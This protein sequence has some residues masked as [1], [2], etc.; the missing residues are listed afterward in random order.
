M[1]AGVG[2]TAAAVAAMPDSSEVTFG[3]NPFYYDNWC[4]HMASSLTYLVCIYLFIYESHLT[5]HTSNADFKSLLR[6]IKSVRRNSH[7]VTI[8]IS[9]VQLPTMLILTT[10][11]VMRRINSWGK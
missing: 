1:L 11:M 7:Q 10:S 2:V 5:L 6:M 4:N 8:E 9:P 3:E